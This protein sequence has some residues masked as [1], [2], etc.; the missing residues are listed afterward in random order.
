MVHLYTVPSLN[1]LLECV[2]NLPEEPTLI[3]CEDK[4]T[5]A[6]EECITK[7]KG[8]TFCIEVTT[9]SRFILQHISTD[10]ILSSQGAVLKIASILAKN[11][12]KLHYLGKNPIAYAKSIY[13]T[14]VQ[15]RACDINFDELLQALQHENALQYKLMDLAFVHEAYLAYIQQNNLTDDNILMSLFPEALKEADVAD[16]HILFVGHTS[17]T[18]QGEYAIKA[19]LQLAKKVSGIFIGGKEN[20]YCN[21]AIDSFKNALTSVKE[22]SIE[23]NLPNLAEHLRKNITAIERQQLKTDKIH[24]FE[25]EDREQEVI[26]VAKQIKKR[27]AKG[28]RYR[29]CSIYVGNLLKYEKSIKR[30]FRYYAIPHFIDK[31]ADA[32]THPLAQFIM[33]FYSLAAEY[34]DPDTVDIFLANHYL[35]IENSIKES[36]RNYLKRYANYR[37]GFK[38]SFKK[39]AEDNIYTEKIAEF[40]KIQQSIEQY[41]DRMQG[42][43]TGAEYCQIL[44]EFLKEQAVEENTKI[45]AEEFEGIDKIFIE[46]GAKKILDFIVEIE[47]IL[48]TDSFTVD[49]FLL[50]FKQS[51]QSLEDIA[52]LPQRLDE[53]YI[54]DLAESRGQSKK[55]VFILG[56]TSDIPAK[57]LDTGLISDRDIDFLQPYQIKINPKIKEVNKRLK[58]VVLLNLASFSEE[59][60]VSYPKTSDG[61]TVKKGILVENLMQI[62]TVDIL[63]T[64]EENFNAVE[65]Y[66]TMRNLL[67]YLERYRCMQENRLVPLQ[68]LASFMQVQSDKTKSYIDMPSYEEIP[69]VKNIENAHKLLLSKGTLSA[70][71]IEQH[72]TC[73]YRNFLERGLHLVK[74]VHGVVDARD[75]GS[76]VHAVLEAISIKIQSIP[77]EELLE[78]LPTLQQEIEQVTYKELENSN[79]QYLTE[80]EEEK[81]KSAIC[82][83][84]ASYL[85]AAVVDSIKESNFSIESVEKA[86][87]IPL[88]NCKLTGVIDRIDK[89]DESGSIR[90]IDYKT[91]ANDIK[92]EEYY[93]GKKVQL[94]LYLYATQ[95]QGEIDNSSYFSAKIEYTEYGNKQEFE[96]KLFSS[97]LDKNLDK[98]AYIAYAIELAEN[99]YDEVMQGKLPP[100]PY[101]ESCTTCKYG[102]ICRYNVQFG[103]RSVKKVNKQDIANYINGEKNN[104]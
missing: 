44:L 36:Y 30:V 42:K 98:N 74:E 3:F 20:F 8:A 51:L 9:F 43:H 14:L 99:C 11:K 23:S 85:L 31:K 65:Y 93:A 70:T 75:M 87:T 40:N 38:K 92:K 83:D 78:M 96:K 12:D 95:Q 50:L 4:L 77:K 68:Q 94:P 73:P 39:L 15:L 91:G 37:G 63:H 61:N 72:Y 84:I 64:E 25:A 79:F 41:I 88:K 28:D 67:V 80:T 26:E 29:D 97:R 58:E 104:E 69:P 90:V 46:N 5:F 32:S 101:E 7:A 52:F 21:H 82:K 10:Y 13:A 100:S 55:Y 57:Q 34:F 56:M 71:F 16:K 76:L 62:F 35:N 24:F 19:S 60:I 22:F 2:A 47:S 89:D 103:V 33:Q 27:I 86:F 102:G 53:V 48:Q 54:G 18:K 1:N 6:L 17:F 81:Y 59:L 45:L 49:E 66:P